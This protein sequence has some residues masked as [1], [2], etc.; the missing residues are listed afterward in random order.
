MVRLSASWTSLDRVSTSSMNATLNLTPSMDVVVANSR[1]LQSGLESFLTTVFVVVLPSSSSVFCSTGLD[2]VRSEASISR[3]LPSVI[4]PRTSRARMSAHVVFP[5]PGGP[6]S[7]RCGRFPPA[8]KDLRRSTAC[9]WPMTPS[10]S[11]G[12]YFSIQMESMVSQGH[13]G[14]G[15]W[16]GWWAFL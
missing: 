14:D 1:I 8:E 6:A 11:V 2:L 4:P 16:I 10:R 3:K 15:I 13:G 12:L 5:L 9:G 7:R